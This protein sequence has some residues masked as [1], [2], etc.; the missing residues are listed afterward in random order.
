MPE[1]RTGTQAASSHA[2][3]P[4]RIVGVLR[5]VPCLAALSQRR[6]REAAAKSFMV[7]HHGCSYGLNKCPTPKHSPW[8]LS[9]AGFSMERMTESG[10]WKVG[11][12]GITNLSFIFLVNR[13][14]AL[15]EYP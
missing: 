15:L 11:G 7:C 10:G 8:G 13:W 9:G 12:R 6:H 2:L 4:A 14:E 1:S 5:R 3:R